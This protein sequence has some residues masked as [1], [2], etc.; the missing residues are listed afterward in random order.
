MKYIFPIRVLLQFSKNNKIWTYCIFIFCL[1]LSV[2][3]GYLTKE[4]QNTNAVISFFDHWTGF[5][6]N[7]FDEIIKVLYTPLG[8]VSWL[9]LVFLLF[10]WILYRSS[11]LKRLCRFRDFIL[12]FVS[13]CFFGALISVFGFFLMLFSVQ[14]PYAIKLAIFLYWLIFYIMILI[15]EFHL[16]SIRSTVC[17]II[18]FL[19]VFILGGFPSIAPYLQWI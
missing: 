1:T 15:K 7:V 13:L 17:I 8:L 12:P 4:E 18:S 6:K 10:L 14:I 19:L 2:A 3:K 16:G 5:T 11:G 9:L